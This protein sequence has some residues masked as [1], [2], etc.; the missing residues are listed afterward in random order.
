M[1][2]PPISRRSPDL[3]EEEEEDEMFGLIHNFAT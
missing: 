3:E 1:D 2:P